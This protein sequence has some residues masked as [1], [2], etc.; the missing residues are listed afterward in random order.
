MKYW[1]L[2]R[3]TGRQ[4]KDLKDVHCFE[5]DRTAKDLNKEYRFLSWCSFPDCRVLLCSTCKTDH[6]AMHQLAGDEGEMT[7]TRLMDELER[8]KL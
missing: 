1:M 4:Y 2:N 7:W 3:I 6:E 5:C 8:S